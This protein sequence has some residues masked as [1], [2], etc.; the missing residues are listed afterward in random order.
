MAD[1][2]FG[3]NDTVNEFLQYLI[4]EVII[5]QLNNWKLRPLPCRINNTIIT[6]FLPFYGKNMAKYYFGNKKASFI[7]QII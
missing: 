3:N 2:Y 6:P 5:R 7:I 4:A 1:H